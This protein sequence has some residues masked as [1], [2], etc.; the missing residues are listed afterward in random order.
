MGSGTH[1]CFNPF[2]IVLRNISGVKMAQP[3]KIEVLKATVLAAQREFDMA[4]IFHSTWKPAAFDESLHKKM[5][6][7]FAGHAFLAIR[8][9][10]RREMLLA[11]M[12]LWDKSK[13]T[14]SM[15][16][17]AQSLQDARTIERLIDVRTNPTTPEYYRDDLR[18]QFSL[19]VTEI[20]SI[21]GKYRC[22]GSHHKTFKW[23]QTLRHE[24]LAHTRI[25]QIK[26]EPAIAAEEIEGFYRD[27]AKLIQ[28]LLH[29]V[30]ATAYDPIE[31]AHVYEHHALDFWKQVDQGSPATRRPAS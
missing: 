25:G 16:K 1:K 24:S 3:V 5:S 10:L 26:P 31:T 2:V 18:Q 23:I 9:A 20:V 11:L 8:T 21:V 17:L 13:G 22:G 28:A 27:N 30:C 14:V 29:L 4:V 6:F 7:C 15:E 12:R 19:W